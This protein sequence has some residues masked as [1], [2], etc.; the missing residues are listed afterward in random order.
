MQVSLVRFTG[1][2]ITIVSTL[3]VLLGFP[4]GQNDTV[5]LH[6]AAAGAHLHC[7]VIEP[8]TGRCRVAFA[9]EFAPFLA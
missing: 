6:I 7:L 9:P 1:A 2:K 5:W 8:R 3:T 4:F